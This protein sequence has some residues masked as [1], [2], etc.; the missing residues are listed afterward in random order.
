MP[1]DAI[2]LLLFQ[3]NRCAFAPLNHGAKLCPSYA[4]VRGRRPDWILDDG[5]LHDLQLQQTKAGR[6]RPI[7][8][9]SSQ[10]ESQHQP[11]H[12]QMLLDMTLYDLARANIHPESFCKEQISSCEFRAMSPVVER[13]SSR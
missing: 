10:R 5:F 11:M 6:I 2:Y 4:F 1:V 3:V 13:V 9:V 12:Q 7:L 8:P